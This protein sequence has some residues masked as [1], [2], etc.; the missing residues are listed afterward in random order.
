MPVLLLLPPLLLL[1]LLQ[2]PTTGPELFVEVLGTLAAACDVSNV[3]SAGN[4]SSGSGSGSGSDSSGS[5]AQLIPIEELL[6][7]LQACFMPG[8]AAAIAAAA[9]VL[10]VLS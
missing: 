3:S 7:L 9:A 6:R 8:E 2:A 1:L 5:L 4:G 10:W